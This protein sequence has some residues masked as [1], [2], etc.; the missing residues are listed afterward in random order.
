MAQEKALTTRSTTVVHG[1][2]TDE[3]A[4]LRA[5]IA[6][7][8]ADL[9]D[10]LDAIQDRLSPARL[11]QRA[12]DSVRDATIGRVKHMA[13]NVGDRAGGAGRGFME[14]VRDNPMPLALI[15]LG[16]GWLLMNRRR[17]HHDEL[18]ATEH[19]PLGYESAYVGDRGTFAGQEYDRLGIRQQS[20]EGQS[21]DEGVV[22]R[23]R[24]RVSDA[25]HAVG[26]KV[27]DARDTVKSAASDVAHKLS[28]ASD[29]VRERVSGRAHRLSDATSRQALRARYTYEQTPWVGVA[30]ALAAGAM[31]GMAIPG[32]RRE[33]ELLGE[34]RD[35]LIGR[36]RET[37][38]EK[39]EA[40]KTVAQEVISEVK[41]IAE[42]SAREHA[43][44]EGLIGREDRDLPGTV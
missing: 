30:V 23:A 31:A 2:L 7:T 37:G 4:R 27:G 5:D 22:D 32:T 26:E 25:A 13:R 14:V 12:K 41:P 28:H 24:E 1:E 3:V 15:G 42:E 40:A 44:E 10:T 35:A 21:T 33:D 9:G 34:T 43:R 20:F 11:K 19:T 36:A 17:H 38:R 18:R 39:L 29:E 8:R 16:A 6:H